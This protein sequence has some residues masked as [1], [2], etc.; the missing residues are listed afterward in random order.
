MDYKDTT[1]YKNLIDVP[2]L[3]EAV[4]GAAPDFD[5]KIDNILF[6][7]E[8]FFDLIAEGFLS[9]RSW[10]EFLDELEDF[11]AVKLHVLKEE[12]E[13]NR[14]ENE[15]RQARN[16]KIEREQRLEDE[17]REREIRAKLGKEKIKKNLLME[18]YDNPS[19]Y[20]T[21]SFW[22]LMSFDGVNALSYSR[23]Q[24]LHILCKRYVGREHPIDMRSEHISFN[25]IVSIFSR[26]E[27]SNKIEGKTWVKDW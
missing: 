26:W 17:A 24:F 7:M 23:E 21:H 8:D 15:L 27:Y 2:S 22:R 5:R 14:I 3:I 13:K 20:S 11:A 25:E 6:D 9:P 18:V 12:H 4:R 16:A 1:S 10:S 19:G